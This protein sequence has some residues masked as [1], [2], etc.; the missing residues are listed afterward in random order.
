[1]KNDD[2]TIVQYGK[3]RNKCLLQNLSYWI[4]F[5][6]CH[7]KKCLFKMHIITKENF[8]YKPIFYLVIFSSQKTRAFT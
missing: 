6:H 8:F 4:L 5:T 3:H 1:M 2:Y 7:A